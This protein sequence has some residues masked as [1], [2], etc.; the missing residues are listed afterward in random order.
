MDT[1]QTMVKMVLDRWHGLVKRTDG[2][3]DSITDEQLEREIAPGS[4]RGIYVLGHI[5]AVND[6]M[7]PILDF[8]ERLFPEL[9]EPFIQQPDKS[10]KEIPSAKKLRELWRQQN[11]ILAKKFN[12]L[13]TNEWFE[14]HTSVSAEDFIKEPHRNKLNIIITRT[15]HLSHHS[16]QLALIK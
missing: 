14:K 1:T 13:Q 3:I 7:L 5:I 8:G 10:V 11:E 15:S 4:N 2:I 9:N 16:G 12:G 6:D